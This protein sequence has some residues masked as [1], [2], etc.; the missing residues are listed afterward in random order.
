MIIYIHIFIDDDTVYLVAFKHPH[1][2]VR[3]DAV[4][5]EETGAVAAPGD[6]ILLRLAA[7]AGDLLCSDVI[8]IHHV[9]QD[10]VERQRGDASNTKVRLLVAGQTHDDM[11]R[12]LFIAATTGVAG[13][14]YL[15]E[16]RSAENMETTEDAWGLKALAAY[17]TDVATVSKQRRISIL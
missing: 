5:A 17:R 9:H 14:R 15:F 12:P 11:E 16:A 10:D 13:L 6:C 2:F 1:V 7:G 8:Y 4:G 3:R